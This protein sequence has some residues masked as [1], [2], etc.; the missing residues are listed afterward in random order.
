MQAQSVC[1]RGV[2]VRRVVLSVRQSVIHWGQWCM[3]L[4]CG[5][6]LTDTRAD[7]KAASEKQLL[8]F[9]RERNK[10]RMCDSV[11]GV[12]QKVQSKSVFSCLFC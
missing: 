4:L 8:I 11:S 7:E 1:D 5:L 9:V 6:L 12:C 3:L 2:V 10:V